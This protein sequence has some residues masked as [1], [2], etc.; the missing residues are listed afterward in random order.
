MCVVSV[1]PPPNSLHDQ[2]STLPTS[3]GYGREG[4]YRRLRSKGEE[5]VRVAGRAGAGNVRN[6]VQFYAMAGAAAAVALGLRAIE[7]TRAKEAVHMLSKVKATFSQ[8]TNITL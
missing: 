6:G 4:G 5:D 7:T 3:K 2:P 8:H 1:Q